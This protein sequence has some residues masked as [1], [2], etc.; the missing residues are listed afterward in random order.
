[1]SLPDDTVLEELI[2]AIQRRRDQR[3]PL[4]CSL[5]CAAVDI[6]WVLHSNVGD[7]ANLTFN[8]NYDMFIEYL[9]FDSRTPLKETGIKEVHGTHHLITKTK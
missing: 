5:P 9:Q 3:E 7:I 6:C 4:Y 2:R 1:M 8:K